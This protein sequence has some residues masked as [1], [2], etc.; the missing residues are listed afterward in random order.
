MSERGI[1]LIREELEKT[2]LANRGD[3][4]RLRITA[5]DEMLM[6]RHIFAHQRTLVDPFGGTATDEF[7]FITSPFD[8]T[9]YPIDNP[10]L[11]Q[12]PQFFRK[13]VVDFLVPSTEIAEDCWTAIHTQVCN[14][15]DSY[16]R[17]DTLLEVETVRCGE[18]LEE[19]GSTSGSESESESGSMP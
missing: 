6:P 5:V 11:N 19:V 18:E 2:F 10:D 16:N 9:I 7:C 14:L 17:L 12:F 13:D 1:S 8:A 4:F 15:V 3:V